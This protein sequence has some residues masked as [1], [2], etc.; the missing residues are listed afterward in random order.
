[1][2]IE[3]PRT[4][5]DCGVYMYLRRGR[6]NERMGGAQG[7]GAVGGRS[8]DRAQATRVGL[9]LRQGGLA[10]SPDNQR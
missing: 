8:M 2:R 4:T 3:P 10:R 7:A 9:E 1:M 5:L 6:T